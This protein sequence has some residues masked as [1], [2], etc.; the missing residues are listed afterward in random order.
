MLD[1][2]LDWFVSDH[3]QAVGERLLGRGRREGR[4]HWLIL[5]ERPWDQGIEEDGAFLTGHCL[6]ANRAEPC[7]VYCTTR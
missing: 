5:S 2:N 6:S 3:A 4:D 1:G 7:P